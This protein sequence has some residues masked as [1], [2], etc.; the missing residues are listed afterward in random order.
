MAV[1]DLETKNA[2]FELET[3]I[4]DQIE[5]SMLAKASIV[6]NRRKL[7][8]HKNLI[9]NM[10]ANGSHIVPRLQEPS[11]EKPFTSGL[12]R[13]M[14]FGATK[15]KMPA[16]KECTDIKARPSIKPNEAQASIKPNKV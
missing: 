12:P 16:I 5:D 4:G 10:K 13:K 3:K 6:E 15:N 8:D 14:T 1:A 11:S 7:H 2:N 9:N